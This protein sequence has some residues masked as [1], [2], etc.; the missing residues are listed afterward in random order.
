MAKKKIKY[1]T[2]GYQYYKGTEGN[3]YQRVTK[4]KRLIDEH[5]KDTV[6][7]DELLYCYK[8]LSI[9]S[10]LDKNVFFAIEIGFLTFAISFMLE[11]YIET[12]AQ[13]S[14]E[15][16]LMIENPLIVFLISILILAISVGLMIIFL[17]LFVTKGIIKN[18]KS[19]YQVFV[20]PYEKVIV[21]RRL[22]EDEELKELFQSIKD[23]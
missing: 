16:S 22:N 7:K 4:T 17:I 15:L 23:T 5:Y 8:K 10:F 21:E 13:I 6:C 2:V 9:L 12:Y 3:R 14:E 11:N 18:F 20:L 1:N 19:D